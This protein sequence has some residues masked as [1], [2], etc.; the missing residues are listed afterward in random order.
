MAGQKK[1]PTGKSLR[2]ELRTPL[3]QIIGY[4]EL[5]QEEAEEAGQGD[6]VPDLKK[7]EQAGRKLLELI[8]A[9]PMP[10]QHAAQ[11]VALTPP[12]RPGPDDPPD[13]GEVAPVPRLA[14]P[15]AEPLRPTTPGEAPPPR[16][17]LVVDDNEI[18]RDM[19]ARRL[20][21]KGFTV[22]TAGG[23]LEALELVAA[24]A[25]TFDLIL[26]DVMMPEMTGLEVL[27]RLRR[28]HTVAELPV[29][30]A[31]ARDSSE[32]IVE[33]F[34]LGANDYVTKP[35]DMPVVLARVENQL[36][37][38]E[39]R[40]QVERL[41]RRVAEAQA[42][43]ADLAA[44]S[45]EA[46]ADLDS[47]TT[48]MATQ[49][50]RAVRADEIAVWLQERDE[51]RPVTRTDTQA[52][53][54]QE[55]LQMD[56][57]E[58]HLRR[59]NDLIISVLGLTGQPFGALVVAGASPSLNDTELRLLDSFSRQLGGAVELRKMQRDLADAEVKRQATRQEMLDKGVTLLQLCPTC[60]RCFSHDEEVCPEDGTALTAPRV[61]PYV[62][63]ERYRLTHLLGEGGMGLVFRARDERLRRDVAVK[64]IKGELLDNEE[65]R[66]RFQQEAR[67]VARIDH[68]GVVAVY[69]YGD[70]QDGSLFLVMELLEGCELGE[71]MEQWGPGTP[72]QVGRLL[73][74][75]AAGLGAAHRAGLV[76]RDLK[77]ENIFL[78]QDEVGFD[79]KIVDFGVAKDLDM[80]TSLTRTG[81][82]VGTPRYMSPEQA[83]GNKV[84]ARSD[85]YSFAAVAYQALTGQNC[86]E[87]KTFIKVLMEIVSLDSRLI[88]AVLPDAPMEVDAAFQ[89]ALDK[90]ARRR[91]ED[92]E[93][94]VDSFIL[95]LEAWE[96][97]V[98]GW[99]TSYGE[100]RL[101]H[102]E[103]AEWTNSATNLMADLEWDVEEV[104]KE[105]GT[106]KDTRPPKET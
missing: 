47:W 71:M 80:D 24:R 3:N 16:A 58:S 93:Q 97:Q 69:D 48:Q 76:H 26:L 67:A 105:E 6:F 21:R 39:A 81:A 75:G 2:H 106:R 13:T 79:V 14:P 11:T 38:K 61:I 42:H 86:T 54:R 91:P 17:L 37:L 92:V 89:W 64:V 95:P 51:L 46:V 8:N 43:I 1:G 15:S 52:P 73:R 31:T 22:H 33:A 74:L 56:R 60:D 40:E 82:L 100:L 90:D 25:R 9:I 65:L 28:T 84:D 77:P 50:A 29:I 45:A 55:L 68:P 101:V 19:L 63:A 85:I 32:D 12:P 88:S 41:N 7:I 96:R 57:T 70:L 59:D 53:T 103:Q 44:S 34:S 104:T 18:N 36:Q 66:Q 5:L 94:W 78:V 102:D 99:L 98:N 4:S 23:G 87:E 72:H 83:L 20:R 10:R 62:V 35:L 30:M 49:V 27:E